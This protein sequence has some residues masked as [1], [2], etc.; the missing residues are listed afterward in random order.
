MSPFFNGLAF[1]QGVLLGNLV[2][3]NIK[4]IR[5]FCGKLSRDTLNMKNFLSSGAFCCAVFLAINKTLFAGGFVPDELE[6]PGGNSVGLA[7]GGGA[8]LDDYSAVRI[9]PAMLASSSRYQVAGTYFWPS[10]GR[11]FFQVGVVDGTNKSLVAG[12]SYTAYQDEF[13]DPYGTSLTSQQRSSATFDSRTKRKISVGL[14]STFSK[15]ALGITGSQVEG[16]IL[17]TNSF[18]Y[19]EIKAFTL[20]LGAAALFSK[21]LRVG[22]SIENLNNKKVR[23]MAPTAKRF[24]V[25]YLMDGGRVSLHADLV[26]RKRVF[27]ELGGETSL[28]DVL[29]GRASLLGE[30]PSTKTWRGGLS[31]LEQPV[32]KTC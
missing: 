22:L 5:M 16:H 7:G 1:L 12:L 28:V 2:F 9:N 11:D 14:A 21:S 31:Y 32:S 4:G 17:D 6:S 15:V 25:A 3:Y 13:I 24:G 18:E 30:K 10:L 27:S 29:G 26:E 20:N 8:A 23:D 19:S